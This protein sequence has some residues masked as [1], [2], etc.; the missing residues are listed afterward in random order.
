M[1]TIYKYAL[2]KT[3]TQVVQLPLGARIIC[4]QIQFDTPFIW[5]LIDK[6]YIDTESVQITIAGTGHDLDDPGE[7]VGTVQLLKGEW[8]F[9]VFAKVLK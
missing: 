5:V 8:V 3:D 9:H 6:N 1:K 4:T 2:N 7:Y